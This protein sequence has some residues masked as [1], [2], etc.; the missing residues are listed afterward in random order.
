MN[1]I[2]SRRRALVIMSVSALAFGLTACGGGGGGSDTAAGDLYAA[3]DKIDQGMSYEQVRDIVGYEYNDGK[4][5]YQGNE[6]HYKWVS[7]KGTVEVT[8]LSVHISNGRCNAK[9]VV[10]NKGNNSKFW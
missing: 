5:D 6:V 3:F 2:L 4:D 10:G 1:K 8:V 7:G 9:I